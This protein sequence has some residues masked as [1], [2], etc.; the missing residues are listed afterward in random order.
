[1]KTNAAT[2]APT[3]PLAQLNAD[4]GMDPKSMQVM[5]T[6]PGGGAKSIP[7]GISGSMKGAVSCL[8]GKG[9]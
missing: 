8:N 2:K 5:R 9:Y 4:K 6:T 7:E 3:S 1:M